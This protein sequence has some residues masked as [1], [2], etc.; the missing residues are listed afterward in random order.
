MDTENEFM[1]DA[2]YYRIQ[3]AIE[4]MT[5]I[6]SMMLKDLNLIVEDD[7]KNFGKL[8]KEGIFTNTH[9]EDLKKLNGMRNVIVHQY[10]GV[11]EEIIR[12]N[13]DMIQKVLQ[14]YVDHVK[15][16][17]TNNIGKD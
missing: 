14:E 15:Q 6:N 17:L 5:D 2:L 11:E 9:V 10:N 13:T 4:A 3:V 7:Y 16:W 1:R 8:E 12:S